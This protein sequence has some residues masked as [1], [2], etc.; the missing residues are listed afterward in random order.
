MHEIVFAVFFFQFSVTIFHF[1]N[2]ISFLSLITT[3]KKK[4][5][6]WQH[7]PYSN[8]P[9]SVSSRV[10]LLARSCPPV[11]HPIK[12]GETRGERG[13][14]PSPRARLTGALVHEFLTWN[15]LCNFSKLKKRR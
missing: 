1:V 3:N 6:N 13:G 10:N 14:E 9:D 15:F 4:Q 7:C 2:F 12:G 11:L 8:Q 5:S